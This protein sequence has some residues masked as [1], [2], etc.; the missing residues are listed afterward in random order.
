VS[1]LLPEVEVPTIDLYHHW[2]GDFKAMLEYYNP[3]AN[4][5][6]CSRLRRSASPQ[7]CRRARPIPARKQPQDALRGINT[8]A[9]R[10]EILALDKRTE[11]KFGDVTF[12]D[13]R[14]GAFLAIH[15]ATHSPGTSRSTPRTRSPHGDATLEI[16]PA[17]FDSSLE[18]CIGAMGDFRHFAEQG[19]VESATDAHRSSIW[20]WE[21]ARAFDYEPLH[22]IQTVDIARGREECIS[23]YVLFED[24]YVALKREVLDILA[25]ARGGHGCRRWWRSS[26]A[27]GTPCA[28]QDGHGLSQAPVRVDVLIANYEGE[29][30][31]PSQG[32]GEDTFQLR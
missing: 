21:L 18:R 2:T 28:I 7:G 27:P 23:L 31:P 26:R 32:G 3:I 19:Y 4:S 5:P 9:D 8:L 17:F 1:F 24:F 14:S 20:A 29:R 11:W 6:C 15:D 30:D 12:R 22:P 13:G 16:N 10:A 25:R